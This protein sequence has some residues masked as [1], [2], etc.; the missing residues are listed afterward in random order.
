MF[1]DTPNCQHNMG[2]SLGHGRWIPPS[3]S[4]TPGMVHFHT[5]TFH[6]KVFQGR[7]VGGPSLLLRTSPLADRTQT[8][9]SSQRSK[10]PRPSDLGMKSRHGRQRSG[11]LFRRP[12]FAQQRGFVGKG[13]PIHHHILEVIV[14]TAT[15]QELRQKLLWWWWWWWCVDSIFRLV[16]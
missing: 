11:G 15:V 12:T 10:T 7:S 16:V 2:E 5:K 1:C 6:A 8:L 13:D 9:A 4:D 3:P 14:G